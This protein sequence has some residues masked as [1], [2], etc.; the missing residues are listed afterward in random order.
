MK[1][2]YIHINEKYN[3]ILKNAGNAVKY[4]KGSNIFKHKCTS[5]N[6]MLLTD[7]TLDTLHGTN[8][9]DVC[10]FVNT[11]IPK[12]YWLKRSNTRECCFKLKI[13]ILTEAK[14]TKFQSSGL[15]TS[16]ILESLKEFT[17]H[18]DINEVI[19]LKFIRHEYYWEEIQHD[20]NRWTQ[21][22]TSVFPEL[23]MVYGM[24]MIYITFERGGPKL[25]NTTARVLA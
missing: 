15:L 13:F 8:C 14:V 9:F 2:R 19:K 11:Q 18:V 1:R 12:C 3:F 6:Q 17:D 7:G 5:S 22:R 23:Y 25:S 16:N 4:M 24:W 20:S 10:K 21:F